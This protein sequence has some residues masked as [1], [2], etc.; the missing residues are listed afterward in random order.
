MARVPRQRRKA[1]RHIS[2][3]QGLSPPPGVMLKRKEGPHRLRGVGTVMGIYDREYYQR[4]GSSF[5]DSLARQGQ[6]CKTLIAVNVGVFVLQVLSMSPNGGEGPFTRA[7]WVDR[8][9]VLGG[10]VWRLLTYA[11]LHAPDNIW[12]IVFNML[13]LWWFGC[14]ME[15]LYG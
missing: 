15:D 14:D 10:E 8:T 6:V 7:L 13:F 9:D 11:F 3:G 4:E 5:L 2:R 1:L 12:H